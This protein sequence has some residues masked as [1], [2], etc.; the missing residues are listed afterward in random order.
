M[1]STRKLLP[2]ARGAAV[3]VVVALLVPFALTGILRLLGRFLDGVALWPVLVVAGAIGIA[4]AARPRTRAIGV[5]IVVGVV[6]EALF[7]LWLFGE[8]SRGLDGL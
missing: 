3:A 5:G 7:F 6:A 1:A 4:L 8:F 2:P